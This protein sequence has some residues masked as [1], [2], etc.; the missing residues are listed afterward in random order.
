M[1]DRTFH[2]RFTLSAKMGITLFTLLAAYFFWT[3]VAILGILVAI[4][5]VGMIERV[6][7]T[8]YSISLVKPI[9]RNEEMWFLIVSEGRFSARKTIALRDV[10]SIER[11]KTFLGFDHCLV[12]ETT[13][14]KLICVQPDNEEE[15]K[16]R[17]L[18]PK[19]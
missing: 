14:G 9:D 8:T 13:S 7:H 5:I 1:I 10:V 16:R 4:I 18:E 19:C 2:K 15:F 17:M 3:K 12:V 6:L 11:A